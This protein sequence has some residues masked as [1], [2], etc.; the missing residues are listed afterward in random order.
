MLQTRVIPCLLLRNTGFVKTMRF[1][2]PVYLGDAINTVRIFNEKEVDEIAVLDIDATVKGRRPAFKL[3]EQLTSECFMPVSYG[4]GIRNLDDARR[5]L[6][7]GC[8]KIIVNT[9]AAENPGFVEEASKLFGSQSVVVS[10]DVKRTFFGQQRVV[11]RC[12]R[13][14]TSWDAPAYARHLEALGAGEVLLNN[15]DRDGM[16]TGYDLELVRQVSEAVEI[17]VIACGGARG[18]DDFER[19]AAAGAS[20]VAAGSIFVLHG[21]RRAVLISFPAPEQLVGLRGEAA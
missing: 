14:R 8:E 2:R 11:T 1:G 17:P 18:V 3:L 19:A 13:K 5:I 4:G 12:G 15:V 9:C 10:I 20:A 21:P 7:L 16:L 6:G